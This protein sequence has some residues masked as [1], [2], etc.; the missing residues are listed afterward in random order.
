VGSGGSGF[1]VNAATLLPSMRATTIELVPGVAAVPAAK[2]KKL[3]IDDRIDVR[4][5]D[6][7]DFD[8]P[9]AYDAAFWAQPFFPAPTRAATLAMILRSLR[10]GGLLMVQQMEAEPSEA[11]ARAGFTLRRLVARAHDV[12]HARPIDELAAEVERAGFDLVRVTH[13]DF[14]PIALARR[15]R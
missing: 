4:V 10:P 7:R 6:A 14:G 9:S 8:E 2:A 13:T 1:V 11:A 3:G 12:P 15:P 5:M